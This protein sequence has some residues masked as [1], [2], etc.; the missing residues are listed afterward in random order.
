MHA[1]HSSYAARRRRA[2]GVGR[3]GAGSGTAF[4]PPPDLAAPPADAAKSASGLD[5]ARSSRPATAPQK[6]AP[7]DVVTV[8]YTGWVAATASMFDSSHHARQRRRCFR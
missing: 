8:H 6:P 7:T 2:D 1:T 5:L 3:S 4:T